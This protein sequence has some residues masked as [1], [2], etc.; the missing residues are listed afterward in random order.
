MKKMSIL[1][2]LAG[3]FA[4][5]MVVARPGVRG[6]GIP[7]PGL[8]SRAAAY[9]AGQPQ[10]ATPKQPQWKSRDEYDA[11]NVMATEKDPNKR[12]TLAEA[13]IQKFSNSDF[14][15]KAYQVEMGTYAQL[16]AVPK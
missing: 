9:A 8:R 3:S 10:A 11:F 5:L 13:F 1:L 6:S 14:K 15:D 16:N 2:T 4:P 7:V 12:V